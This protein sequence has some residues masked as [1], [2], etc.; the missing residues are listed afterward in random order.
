MRKLHETILVIDTGGG[1]GRT[2]VHAIRDRHVYA[3]L[4]SP[5]RFLEAELHLPTL[6]GLVVTGRDREA[7]LD[8]LHKKLGSQK[9]PFLA[10]GEESLCA[11]GK[12]S[13]DSILSRFLFDSCGCAGDWTIERYI[14]ET[15]EQIRE[16]AGGKRVICGLSGGV[17]SS[18]A[19]L[20]VH[21]ALGDR[22]TC[23]FIDHGFMRKGEPEMVRAMF[24]SQFRI[25]LVFVDAA[26]RFLE[27]VAGVLEPEAK[28]KRIGEEFIRI[29]EQEAEKMG[30]AFLVQG[31][32]YPDVIESGEDGQIVKSH[33]NVGGLPEQIQFEG[34]IEPLRFLFKEEVREVGRALGLPAAMV[35]RQPFPGPGLAIR[36]LGGITKEKLDIL[37]EADAIFCEEVERHGFRDRVSQYFAVMTGLQSVGLIDGRRTYDFTIALRAVKTDDFMA[38]MP[39]EFPWEFL[40]H[41]AG[42]ITGE[43]SHVS[44]VVYELT[45]KPPATIE[46]E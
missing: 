1:L 24:T 19:A 12:E 7:A 17:D 25:P 6:C 28:R 2:L 46:W 10:L 8:S 30:A 16:R 22:L 34:L 5:R 27:S 39:A 43:V 18:V 14:D 37:R 32:I 13:L 9:I 36:C 35:D 15:M 31:T 44:R 21:R 33:H 40:Q 23:V 38:A 11:A 4:I 41:V 26:E 42:R 45:G 3:E 29:F 20:L